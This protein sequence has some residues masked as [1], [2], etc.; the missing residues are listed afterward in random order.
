MLALDRPM[1]PGFDLGVDLLVQ[2]GHRARADP[3]APQRFGDVLHP[4]DRNPGQVHLDQGFLDRALPTPVAL[5]DR[6]LEGLPPQLRHLQR[7]I[8]GASLQRAF[9]IARSRVLPAFTALIAACAAKPIR[10]RI[11]QCVQRLLNRPTHHLAKMI[12]DPSLVDLDHLTHRI[13][14]VH[15]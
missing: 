8:A 10:L 12:A 3:G 11:Q 14:I 5:D 6:R 1:A 2:V 7:N 9:V 4:P 13:L 15:P